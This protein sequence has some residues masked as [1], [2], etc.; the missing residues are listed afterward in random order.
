M[1]EKEI[2]LYIHIPFCK[3]KCYYCDFI[4]FEDKL[5]LD[6]EYV[7]CIEKE[8]AQYGTENKVMAKHNIEPIYVIKTIYIGGGTPSI[9]DEIYIESIMKTIKANFKISEVPEITI[10]V[11]PGMVNKEKLETYRNIGINRLSIGLQTTKDKLLQDI[12]RIHTYKQFEETYKNAREVGF[13]NINIDLMIGLPNQTIEDVKDSV[14]KVIDLKPEHISV[15]SLILEEGTPLEK[16]VKEKKLELISDEEE[17][18]MY[19]YV[20]LMLEKHKFYQYEISNFAR[21][22]FESK[23][24]TDCWEQKEYIGIGVAASSFIEDKR[25]SNI[26]NLEKYIENIENGMPNKNL[27]LEETLDTEAK[28]KEYM[29]LGLRKI[30]GVNILEFEKKFNISPIVKFCRELEKLNHEGLIMVIDEKIKL[31]NKGIDLA[32]LVWEEF[33]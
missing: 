26:Q 29:L 31:T 28:M 4:S 8:I 14:K 6:K 9:L 25:Y 12:G 16:L 32:N 19:W 27:V 13:N 23:H 24:N 17:R 3:K 33:V 11:N 7:E 5:N 30:N 10:E 15:Y 22:G 20:K 21:P 2:G 18:K 1:N